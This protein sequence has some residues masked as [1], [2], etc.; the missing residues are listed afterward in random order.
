MGVGESSWEW[1]RVSES[2]WKW[3]RVAGSGWECNLVKGLFENWSTLDPKN[4]YAISF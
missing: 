3:M 1:L 2:G 4:F